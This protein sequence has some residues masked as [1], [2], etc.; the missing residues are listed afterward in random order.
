MCERSRSGVQLLR[1]F[2]LFYGQS[3]I[4]VPPRPA[5]GLIGPGGAQGHLGPQALSSLGGAARP[6][7][8]SQGIPPMSICSIINLKDII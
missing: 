6:F 2:T 7:T 4:L 5:R 1:E 3:L 8:P